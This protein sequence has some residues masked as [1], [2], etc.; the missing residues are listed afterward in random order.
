[1][2]G[3][4]AA[5]TLAAQ[6]TATSAPAAAAPGSR[7]PQTPPALIVSPPADAVAVEKHPPL[8]GTGN[9]TIASTSTW[10]DVPVMTTPENVPKGT[11]TMFTMRS[12]ETQMF[13]GVAGPYTRNVWVYVPAGYVPGTILPLM[14]DHDGRADAV[15]QATSTRANAASNTTRCQ[16]STLS[17][18]NTKCCRSPRSPHT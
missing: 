11:V 1:M 9:F 18:S 15:I 5:G 3:S 12:E 16:G 10:A 8:D 2:T 7:D 6:A 4:L 14:I 17:S 13:P